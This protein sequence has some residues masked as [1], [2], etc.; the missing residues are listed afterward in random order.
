MFCFINTITF[1]R[2]ARFFCYKSGLNFYKRKPDEWKQ[3][4]NDEL[5]KK[6]LFADILQG[7]DDHAKASNSTYKKKK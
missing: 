1:S 3:I 4:Q 2:Y 7:D 6:R 5:K